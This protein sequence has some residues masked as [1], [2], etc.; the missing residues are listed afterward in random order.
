MARNIIKDKAIKLYNNFV[1]EC[2]HEP[3][4]VICKVAFK[5]E[6]TTS[7][8]IMSFKEFD[9]ENDD[10]IFFYVYDL[11]E[12]L[13]VCDSNNEEDFDVV[14]IIEFRNDINNF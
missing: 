14:D 2:G 9:V 7:E 5:D 4:Y 1:S 3:C 11:E 6:I 12:L 13:E 10:K 8:V